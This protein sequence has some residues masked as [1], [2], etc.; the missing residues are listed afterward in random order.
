VSVSLPWPVVAEV[1]ASHAAFELAV[2]VQSRV[3]LMATDPDIPSAG[4]AS[5]G[6]FSTAT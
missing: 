2:H 4:A 1:M 6:A 5:C 3:V